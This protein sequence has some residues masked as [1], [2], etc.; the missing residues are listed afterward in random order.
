MKSV[1]PS[2]LGFKDASFLVRIARKAVEYYFDHGRPLPAPSDAPSI[3]FRPGAAFVTITTFHSYEHRELRGCIGH[4]T[5]IKPLIDSVIEV[6]IEAAFRDP[7]FPPL[8]RQ[9]LGRVTFEVTV[10]GPLEKLPKEPALRIRSFTIGLHGLVARK[11]Y[12]QGL[13]LPDV[14]LEYLWDEETFLAETCVKAG[15]PPSCWLDP[16]VEFFRFEGRAWR[17]KE[18]LGE[19]EERD[20]VE[21]YRLMLSR[22]AG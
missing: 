10:L 16:S 18:P 8:T 7:R 5:P 15:L 12:L 2:E 1:K 11:G 21:E 17:E 13:L 9:E 20:L 22:L 6:A 4:V 3:V 14:P 19:I